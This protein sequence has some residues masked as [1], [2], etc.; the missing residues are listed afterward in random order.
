MRTC[1]NDHDEDKKH[2]ARSKEHTFMQTGGV[3][4]FNGNIAGERSRLP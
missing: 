4:D 2:H 3:I 1:I